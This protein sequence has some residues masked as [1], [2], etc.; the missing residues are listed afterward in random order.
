MNK[1]SRPTLI[2]VH[3]VAEAF[4]VSVAQYWTTGEQIVALDALRDK[5]PRR[6]EVASA[7]TDTLDDYRE[8]ITRIWSPRVA[9]LRQLGKVARCVDPL[10]TARR[11]DRAGQLL[12][13]LLELPEDK[14]VAAV[15]ADARLRR[16]LFVWRLLDL[17]EQRRFESA[18]EALSLAQLACEAIGAE[19]I[20]FRRE[21]SLE[22]DTAAL[23]KAV[24]ANAMRMLGVWTEASHFS[25]VAESWLRQNSDRFVAGKVYSYRG[26]VQ[27]DV[28]ENEEAERYLHMS[29]ARYGHEFP[30]ERQRS[31]LQ[32]GICKDLR[33]ESGRSEFLAAFTEI[34]NNHAF[35]RVLREKVAINL[36]LCDIYF[37]DVADAERRLYELSQLLPENELWRSFALGLIERS[38]GDLAS[39]R[40]LFR[41]AADGFLK[42]NIA[43][44]WAFVLLHACHVECQ[45][46]GRLPV[47]EVRL[48]ADFLATSKSMKNGAAQASQLYAAC[49]DR[50][51]AAQILGS[52]LF[53][54]RC[55]HATNR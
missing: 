16:P 32:V 23:C 24:E 20:P 48:V 28:G 1:K 27:L 12:D 38:R 34:F 13:E 55:P 40:S 39:A 8:V 37:H 7:L 2:A 3:H 9:R 26:S 6:R 53:S 30:E 45:Q 4:G 51:A 22:S 14:R 25:F 50:R 31:L 36:S 19:R 35:E 21:A 41:S 52:V 5:D 44:P 54:L 29:L 15:R 43:M 42:H 10:E 17:E 46:R 33:N 18:E 49:A 47:S 11:W